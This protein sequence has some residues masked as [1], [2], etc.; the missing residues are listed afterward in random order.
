MVIGT[1]T[2]GDLDQ[3]NNTLWITDNILFYEGTISND[4]S[5]TGTVAQKLGD[6]GLTPFS[7]TYTYPGVVS[8][9]DPPVLTWHRPTYNVLSGPPP[10]T[11]GAEGQL[12]W[13]LPLTL[14]PST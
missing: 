10:L 13:L 14:E 12:C 9:T 11:S 5:F 7:L 8:F 3:V 2:D 1:V 4:K 6:P